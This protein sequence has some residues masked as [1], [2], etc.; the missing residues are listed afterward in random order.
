MIEVYSGLFVG[1]ELDYEGT[2][3]HQD[4]WA[5]VQACKEP[6]HRQALGYVERAAPKMHPEYLVAHRGMRLILNMV[7]VNNPA[8]FDKGMITQALDFIDQQH[9]DKLNVLVHCNQGES[10]GPSIALVYMATRLRV[11]PSESLEAAEEAFRKLYPPYNPK[12]GIRGH[13]RQYW[14][15]Y[16]S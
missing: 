4:G 5:V 14:Q 11:L 10:R 15:Q 2:V 9:S 13:L 3:S 16:C 1:S 6:Y 7:D 8:F 12:M